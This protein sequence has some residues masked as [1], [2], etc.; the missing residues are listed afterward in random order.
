M[1]G[2]FLYSRDYEPPAPIVPTRISVPVGNTGRAVDVVALCDTG[3]DITCVP[4]EM[5]ADLGLVEVDEVRVQAYEGEPVVKPL[6]AALL[7]VGGSYSQIVRVISFDGSD[8]IL[9]RDLLNSLRLELDGPSQ[10]LRLS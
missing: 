6:Y 5:V 4:R 10:V 3:A 7:G 2:T 9:G 1:P 8:A